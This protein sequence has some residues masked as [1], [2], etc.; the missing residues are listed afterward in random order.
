MAL[1]RRLPWLAILLVQV[2]RGQ[3]SEDLPNSFPHVY[4]GQPSGDLS[5]AWQN[6][7]SIPSWLLQRIYTPFTDFEV[8]SQQLP[9]ISFTLPRSFAGN[10][11][12]DRPNHPNNTLFFWALEKSNGSLTA[13]SSSDPWLLWLQ[14]GQVIIY[15]RGVF[16]RLTR[17]AVQGRRVWLGCFLKWVLLFV[18]AVVRKAF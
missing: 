15:S 7:T 12:V 5:P 3:D 13:K 17:N 16:T 8:D 10:I 1:L 6:C 4:P 2:V 11:P 14:G 9:N 18:Y